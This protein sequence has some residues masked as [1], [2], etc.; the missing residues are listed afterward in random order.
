VPC[1][2]TRYGPDWPAFSLEIRFV[3]AQQVCECSGQCGIHHGRR[4]TEHHHTKARWAKGTVRLTVAHLCECSPPCTD[5]NHVIA[6]CQRC[7]LRIDRFRHAQARL[8]RARTPKVQSPD[9]R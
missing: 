8:E 9:N 3:R 1:D 6:A 7:H 2:I 5:P 4:C